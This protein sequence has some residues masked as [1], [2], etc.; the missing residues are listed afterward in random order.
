MRLA[1]SI[2]VRFQVAQELGRMWK[3]VSMDEKDM[4]ERKALADKER[5]A[6]VL[7]RRHPL[8]RTRERF[9]AS[10]ELPVETVT[11]LEATRNADYGYVG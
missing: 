2:L 11:S 3:N 1:S 8:S 4:Y 9:R 10:M 5:Y 6:E 7:L